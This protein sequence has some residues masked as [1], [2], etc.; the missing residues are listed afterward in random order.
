MPTPIS[1]VQPVSELAV[2]VRAGLTQPGQK[3]LPSKYF[4]DDVGSALFEAISLLPEYGLTR[5]DE[6]LLRKYS[7]QV[8]RRLDSPLVVAELGSGTGRKARWILESL[9]RRQ[10]TR[11]YPIEISPAALAACQRELREIDSVAIKGI[12]GE[13]LAGLRE[14]AGEHRG[15]ERLLVLFLGSSIGN[16]EH[17]GAII[18]LQGVRRIIKA[19]DALLLGTD[20]EKPVPQLIAAYD[21]A[22]GVTRAFNL[23]LLARI[24][25]ELGADFNLQRFEHAVLFNHLTRSIEMHLRSRGRQTVT[26]PRAGISV[27]FADG[28]TILSECSHKY[29]LREVLAMSE[30]AGFDCEE[31]FVDREWPFAE[32]LLV[33]K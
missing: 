24:N 8:I 28:E 27:T 19:G 22:P 30:E 1:A 2:D 4:Y 33:A 14:V 21:D 32:S 9:S 23:N 5:A 6:R 11:Y 3:E 7:E 13:Y 25:R 17:S 12:E 15:S 10:P 29:S 26:I 18:F 20:L 31:Q 16:M